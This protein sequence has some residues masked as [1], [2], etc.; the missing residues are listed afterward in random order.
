MPHRTIAGWLLLAAPLIALADAPPAQSLWDQTALGLFKDAHRAF[1]GQ[2]AGDREARFGEAVTL[3]NLQPKTDGNLD[4]AAALFADIAAN[5]PDDDL[6]V[7]A[8]YFTARIAQVHRFT[9]DLNAALAGYRELAAL[10]SPH[11]LAQRAVVQLALSELFDP[12]LSIDD[13][14]SRFQQLA[15]RGERLTVPPVR[16][17]FHLVMGDAALRFKLGHDVALAHLL[18]ADRAGITRAITRRDT[19]L[20]IANLARLTGQD[21]IAADYYG[22]FLEKFPRDSRGLMVREHLASLR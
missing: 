11:P 13:V 21:D 9:P 17:D 2:P 18:A 7:S 16:R 5:N 19:W 15:A 10:D 12:G 3:L 22:R 4:R 1:A 6:G 8:R 20:R 14:R